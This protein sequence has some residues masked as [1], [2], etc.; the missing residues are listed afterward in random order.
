MAF[1]MNKAA[2]NF[3][4]GTGSALTKSPLTKSPPMGSEADQRREAKLMEEGPTKNYDKTRGKVT[5]GEVGPEI[6]ATPKME[7]KRD[8]KK[9]KEAKKKAREEKRDNKKLARLDKK[10]ARIEFGKDSD[11]FKAADAKLDSQKTGQNKVK[12][13]VEETKSKVKEKVGEVKANVKSKVE[14]IKKK[15]TKSDE[16]KELEQKQNLAKLKRK[17]PEKYAKLRTEEIASS[18]KSDDGS[19]KA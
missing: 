7:E 4:Q 18:A 2:F 8:K 19:K 17:N 9:E 12:A 13:K 16:E 15:Y 1:K 5:K 14:D 11:E 3:G 6:V 10:K